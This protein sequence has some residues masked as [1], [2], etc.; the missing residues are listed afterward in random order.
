MVPEAY[1]SILGKAMICCS[2]SPPKAFWRIPAC[3]YW[4]R[5]PRFGLA[6]RGFALDAHDASDILRVSMGTRVQKSLHGQHINSHSVL[7][8]AVLHIVLTA[9]FAVDERVLSVCYSGTRGL[10]VDCQHREAP[11]SNQ[12]LWSPCTQ[13]QTWPW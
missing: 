12:S 2:P 8:F 10:F 13:T 7:F 3:T 9:Y 4:T 1:Q 5:L 6:F 11:W